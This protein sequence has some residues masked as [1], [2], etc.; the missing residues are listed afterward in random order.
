MPEIA[1]VERARL[2][3]H[4]QLIDYKIIDMQVQPDNRIFVN[5]EA[6]EFKK[7]LLNKTLVDTKRR[8]KYFILLFDTEPH[9]VAHLGMTGGI[10][11][12]HEEEVWPPRFWKFQMTFQDPKTDNTIHFGF[13]DP[14]RLG[15]LILVNG[16]PLL[17]EPISKLGFDPVLD[18]PTYEDFCRRVSR[19][20]VPIKSLLLDQSFSAGVGNWVADEILYQA[21]VHPGEYTN[22]LREDELMGI[23]E[24]T[25]SVC[26]LAVK[27]EADE[28][29]FPDDWLM[30][31]RWNKG[32][33]FGKG[34]LPNGVQL[35]FTTV[36]G[37]TS[38]IDPAKQILRK[39]HIKPKRVGVK[40]EKKSVTMGGQVRRK[41]TVVQA[42]KEEEEKGDSENN[43]KPKIKE[44]EEKGSKGIA[45]SKVE[46]EK[47]Q[48][49][50]RR[51]TRSSTRNLG[52]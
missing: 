3:I 49:V 8:G 46:E 41:R 45:A 34:V 30:K 38:A 23:Y 20:A 52:K 11:F 5:Q 24:R 16:D 27:V 17:C 39:P 15:K 37:R 18:M 33:G 51:R 6:E 44:E 7:M 26:A 1:E 19:R 22:T 43:K 28:S 42:E 12:K 29:Q 31:Y 47:D 10:R 21:K 4:R 2:R 48:S 32:K 13:K 14:R 9:L 50:T 35:E 40:F 36:G 25:R